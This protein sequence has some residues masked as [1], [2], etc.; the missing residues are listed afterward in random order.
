VAACPD[1]V[2]RDLLVEHLADE[3]EHGAILLKG[4]TSV[5]HAVAP[6]LCRP[7]PTTV[8][9]VAYL[10]ELGALDWRAYCVALGFLQLTLSGSDARPHGR[11]YEAVAAGCPDAKPLLDAM[12][13][14]DRVDQAGGHGEKMSRLLSALHE[15][16][17]LT[18]ETFARAAVLPQ[19]AWSFLDGIRTHYGHGE[20][21]LAQRI[22]WFAS[23]V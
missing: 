7:L 17:E 9:F 21:A 1:R 20:A 14:H 6:D 3:A 23:R 2:V 5:G 22:G 11:F 18:E 13:E 10:K 8:A 4:L 19:L 12:R 16:H 15:R